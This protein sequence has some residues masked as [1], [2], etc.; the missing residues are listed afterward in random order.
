[1]SDGVVKM[2]EDGLTTA[3]EKCEKNAAIGVYV[4]AE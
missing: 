4:K 2:I 1:M 3:K